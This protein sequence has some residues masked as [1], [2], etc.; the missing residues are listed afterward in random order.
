MNMDKASIIRQAEAFARSQLEKDAS[1]HDWWHV[2]RVA[3]TALTL[4]DTEQAD[5]FVCELAA[6]LHDVADEKICGSEAEG[7]ALLAR[8]LED[9][10]VAEAE[11]AH[12][13]EIIGSM[14]FKGGG[15]PPMKTNEGRVVQD[16]DRLDAIGAIGIS[17]VFAYSGAKARPIH[18]PNVQ[19]R[20]Q[21]TA[22]EYRN[23]RDTAIN[24][25]YEKLLKLKDLMNTDSAKRLAAERHQ[26]ME[27]YLE[28]F[29]REWEGQ[30]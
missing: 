2:R 22:E 9:N 4:A 24:H 5:S 26:F 17:R 19:A 28:R 16:A 15:R 8:W 13:L 11:K 27:Q 21:L 30:A 6:L 3:N 25:F 23:G 7:L 12:V 14:S 1:G 29:Y 20:E 18:D 10:G